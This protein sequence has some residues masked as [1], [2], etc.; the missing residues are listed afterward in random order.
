MTRSLSLFEWFGLPSIGQVGFGLSLDLLLLVILVPSILFV[1]PSGQQNGGNPAGH[2]VSESLKFRLINLQTPHFCQAGDELSPV[3]GGI[4][5]HPGLLLDP[6]DTKRE[7][8]H[9]L[10][11]FDTKL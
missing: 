2:R 6:F 1:A 5:L 3:L 8:S 7:L 4:L 10:D 11:P 9:L